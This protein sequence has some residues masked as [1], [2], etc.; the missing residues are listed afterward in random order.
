VTSAIDASSETGIDGTVLING[1]E[2]N[3]VPEVAD[4]ATPASDAS[5]LLREPCAARRPGASNRFVVDEG[6]RV[7]LAVD[8][9][10]AAPLATRLAAPAPKSL[11][12]REPVDPVDS[13]ELAQRGAATASSCTF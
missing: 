5:K 3:I 13:I 11:A 6:R 7:S 4:L 8:D 9:Y 2:G 12:T 10:L 1:V